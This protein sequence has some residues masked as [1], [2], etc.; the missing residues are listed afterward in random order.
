MYDKNK[1]VNADILW[2]HCFVI[3]KV[4]WNV[5]QVV[6][7]AATEP[8]R[9]FPLSV[10]VP[11]N[12]PEQLALVPLK[13][14]IFPENV[15]AMG[16][17][18]PADDAV[19]ETELPLWVRSIE[20][21]RLNDAPPEVPASVPEYIPDK[22]EPQPIAKNAA[23][24]A[25]IFHMPYLSEFRMKPKARPA[26]CIGFGAWKQCLKRFYYCLRACKARCFSF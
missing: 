2:H 26:R 9:T 25:M 19:P 14:S 5:P 23:K 17:V 8:E 1:C 22:L 7:A 16:E 13:L 18:C 11:V 3:L 6:L 4:A 12:A 24:T 21:A 15:P 20:M 10:P